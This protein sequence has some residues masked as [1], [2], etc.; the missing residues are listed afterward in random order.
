MQGVAEVFP[1]LV[2]KRTFGF[3][4]WFR[5]VA[6]FVDAHFLFDCCLSVVCST[7]HFGGVESSSAKTLQFDLA[8]WVSPS[9]L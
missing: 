7:S 3:L 6:V 4:W 9:P 1:F 5:I 8:S 2:Q